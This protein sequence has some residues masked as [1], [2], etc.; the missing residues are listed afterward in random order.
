M[1]PLNKVWVKKV[2]IRYDYSPDETKMEAD[3][4]LEQSELLASELSA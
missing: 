1:N 2:S 3:R 4:V